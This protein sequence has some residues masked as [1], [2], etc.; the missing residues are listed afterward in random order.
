[1]EKE[2]QR[3]DDS[4]KKEVMLAHDFTVMGTPAKVTTPKGAKLSDVIKEFIRQHPGVDLSQYSVMC[5]AKQI[6][7]NT[8]G[9]LK[10][11]PVLIKASVISLLKQIRGG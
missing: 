5:N 6:E 10:E 1:M 8:D 9:S 7:K 4:G 2:R 3:Q 11:D